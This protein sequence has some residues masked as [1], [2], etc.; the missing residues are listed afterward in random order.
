M[1]REEAAR[2]ARHACVKAQPA[3]RRA[4]GGVEPP[5]AASG[6]HVARRR[7]DGEHDVRLE[8]ILDEQVGPRARTASNSSAP[9]RCAGAAAPPLATRARR[10]DRGRARHVALLHADRA[11]S[12]GA[13]GSLTRCIA[14]LP[15]SSAH[16][17]G[18]Q[19]FAR[20]AGRGRRR[21]G[22]GPR[23]CRPRSAPRAA[24]ALLAAAAHRRQH[25]RRRAPAPASR[26]RAPRAQRS[27]ERTSAAP[28][29]RA[30]SSRPAQKWM[31]DT[32]KKARSAATRLEP[33]AP[34][35]AE[36]G[37]ARWLSICLSLTRAPRAQSAHW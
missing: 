17:D 12:S 30:S 1:A 3:R 25:R 21:A 23:R 20:A 26:R 31:L 33:S 13:G 16:A 2:A 29:S 8:R 5:S 4:P 28:P 22:P 14:P 11:A 35:S 9:P 36:A 24:V 6:A 15:Q 7:V 10:A 19:R 32:R 18:E 27:C 37:A 34:R